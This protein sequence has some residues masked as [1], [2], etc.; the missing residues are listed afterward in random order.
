MP[1]YPLNDDEVA[2]AGNHN[3]A[4]AAFDQ[5]NESWRVDLV[6]FEARRIGGDSGLQL[7][8]LDQDAAEVFAQKINYTLMKADMFKPL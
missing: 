5:E 8:G 3:A 2:D 1:D 4:Y 6:G 7:S